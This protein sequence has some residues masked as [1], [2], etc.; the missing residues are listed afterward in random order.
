VRWLALDVGA[1]R[2]GVALCDPQELVV[3]PQRVLP[4]GSVGELAQRVRV[5][6]DLWEVDG[7][8]VGKPLTQRGASPGEARVE[9]VVGALKHA[10]PVPVV[11]FDERGTSQEAQAR[12]RELGLSPGRARQAVDAVAAAVLLEA[13]LAWS[14]AHKGTVDGDSGGC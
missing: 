11:T 6:V 10:L 4:F 14:K 5:L 2:V 7:V 8:V 12:L 13:F 9:A 1:K 3:T